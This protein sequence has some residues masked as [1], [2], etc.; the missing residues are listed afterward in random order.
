MRSIIQTTKRSKGRAS[1]SDGWAYFGKFF[2][3]ETLGA[4][5]GSDSAVGLEEVVAG[6]EAG[7]A[8]FAAGVEAGLAA[9][10]EAGLAAGLAG[11]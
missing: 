6:L 11:H 10:V 7:V 9:G 3:S 5:W 8:G 1:A 2:G 4:P